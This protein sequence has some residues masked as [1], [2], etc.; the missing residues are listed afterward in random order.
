MSVVDIFLL[1]TA[2]ENIT[3]F[4]SKTD[5]KGTLRDHSVSISGERVW[6]TGM[7]DPELP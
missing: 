5:L 1:E 6:R 2:N 3:E 7:G 4:M